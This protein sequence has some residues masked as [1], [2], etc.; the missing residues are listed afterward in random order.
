MNGQP[1]HSE[2]MVRS[3][4]DQYNPK[5]R[6]VLEVSLIHVL[7]NYG[8]IITVNTIIFCNEMLLLEII[9]DEQRRICSH[10]TA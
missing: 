3:D 7:L 6:N 2:R 9:D 5:T 1:S 8:M 10:D 4:R